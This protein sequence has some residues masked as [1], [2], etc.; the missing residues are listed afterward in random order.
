M[1]SIRE[2]C[3]ENI[4]PINES[5]LVSVIFILCAACALHF[6]IK[7]GRAICKKLNDFWD[8][9][10]A[11]KDI[12]MRFESKEEKFDKKKV[13]PM[14]ID[15]PDILE[16]VIAKTEPKTT[17]KGGKGF[18]IFNDLLKDDP[19]LKKINKAPYYP[20]YVVFMDAGDEKNPDIRPNFYGM[21]GFSIKYWKVVSKK[22]KTDDIKK[23]AAEHKNFI[24]IFAVQTDP[25]YA[26][27]GLFEVYLEALKKAVKETKME[28]LTIKCDDDK[29][30][31]IFEKYGFKKIDNL[32]G[33]LS[34]PLKEKKDEK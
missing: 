30:T 28:G 24:N 14:Q 27:Q 25:Q 19:D 2:Y 17:K 6:G 26:K 23:V 4:T 7:I 32:K 10:L 12:S 15:K 20:N 13:Q 31:E 1:K 34:L 5:L 16:K 33:Y 18:Y 8:W 11:E 9:A 21:L 22:G 3:K 29:L